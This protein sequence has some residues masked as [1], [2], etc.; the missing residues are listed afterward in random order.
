MS[1]GKNNAPKPPD[2][3]GLANASLESAKVWEDVANK[4]LDWAKTTDQANRDLLGKVIGVQL[5]QLQD[6]YDAA[7]ADRQRYEQTFQPLEDKFVQEA[8]TYDTPERR[9]AQAARMQADVNTQ[10][11]AQRANATKQLEGYGIDPSQTR[12]GALDLGYRAQ[13]AAAGALASSVR[14]STSARAIRR[15]WRSR[16]ASSTRQRVA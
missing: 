9:A 5:P 10:F 15:K 2:Y 14:R 13:Q 3:S 7:K 1:S 11:E 4:Q 6:A 16:K 12:M 8:Q